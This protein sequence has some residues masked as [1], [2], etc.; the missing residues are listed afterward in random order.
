MPDKSGREKTMTLLEEWP[1]RALMF[2][3]DTNIYIVFSVGSW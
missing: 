3:V 1:G 2:R